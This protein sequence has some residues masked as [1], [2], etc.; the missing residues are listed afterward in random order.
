MPEKF[1]NELE[2]H[3]SE[4]QLTFLCPACPLSH[5]VRVGFNQGY[6]GAHKALWQRTGE[7][8]DDLTVFP[9]ING[10]SEGMPCVFHG[11]IRG[12]MVTW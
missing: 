6:E 4:N 9:S 3:L 2:A 10:E 11:Q 5:T 1:L 12:G 7:S 8:V